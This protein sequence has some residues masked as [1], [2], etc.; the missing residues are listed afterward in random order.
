MVEDTAVQ[1]A[2]DIRD[3]KGQIAELKG[4]DNREIIFRET[5][6]QKR[7]TTIYSMSNGEPLTMPLYIAEGALSKRHPDGTYWFTARQEEA[8]EYRL[9]NIKCFLHAE[10]PDHAILELIGLHANPCR[11][12]TL[13]NA[14]SKRM[15]ALHRHPEEWAAYQEH[16]K[17][18]KERATEERAQAQLDATLALA[19]RAAGNAPVACA[20]CDYT[21]TPAQINGH[22]SVHNKG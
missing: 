1:R 20:E 16:V 10:S 19:G 6:P 21:G 17:D 14:H 22:K 13:A 3:L 11:K 9:G 18:E 7:K 2:Q 12:A 8:P 5:S 4:E 15:H